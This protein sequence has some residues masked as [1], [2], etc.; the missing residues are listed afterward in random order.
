MKRAQADHT[1]GQWTV[2]NP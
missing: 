2:S 1:Y